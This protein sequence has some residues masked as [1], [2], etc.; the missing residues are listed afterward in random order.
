[1][2]ATNDA[3]RS[4]TTMPVDR[5][6]PNA[7]TWLGGAVLVLLGGIF[8][9]RNTGV[10]DAMQHWWAL[11]L[12]IPIVVTA[13]TAWTQYQA[14]GR[15]LTPAVSGPLA[16]SLIL[17]VVAAIFLLNLHWGTVWPVFLIIAGVTSLLQW[18]GWRG[19]DR[20]VRGGMGRRM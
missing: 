3:P 15:R 19:G 4:N 13:G 2:N 12:L 16:A 9:L 6:M 18:A 5:R 20:R 7:Y 11:F 1:M 14:S 17:A 10:I 8:L